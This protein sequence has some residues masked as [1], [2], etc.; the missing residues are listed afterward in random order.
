MTKPEHDSAQ[1]V[2]SEKL[3]EEQAATEANVTPQDLMLFAKKIL[4]ALGILFFLGGLAEC[5]VPIAR[6][7]K[8][9]KLFYHL[10]PHWLSVI[11][12]ENPHK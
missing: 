7:L 4:L 6:S 1:A 10:S 2:M 12:L 11:I 5:I 8:P 9:A 3:T